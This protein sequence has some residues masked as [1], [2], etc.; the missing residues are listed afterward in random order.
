MFLPSQPLSTPLSSRPACVWRSGIRPQMARWAPGMTGT[1]WGRSPFTRKRR[2]AKRQMGC[3]PAPA[4]APGHQARRVSGGNR[5]GPVSPRH[6]ECAWG[7]G[8]LE[9][10]S[11]PGWARSTE[12]SCWRVNTRGGK[13]FLQPPLTP[14]SRTHWGGSRVSGIRP[15]G[16]ASPCAEGSDIPG[17]RHLT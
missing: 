1:S 3:Y 11:R 16:Q 6:R 4:P 15:R 7:L 12:P 10:P 17:G 13:R 14:N 2:T 9:G 8:P 5:L